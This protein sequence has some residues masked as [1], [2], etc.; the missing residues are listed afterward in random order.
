MLSTFVPDDDQQALGEA[1]KKLIQPFDDGYWL[2]CDREAAFPQAFRKAVADAGW[3]GIA[4][5]TS[6]GGA[7]LGVTEAAVMMEAIANSPGGMAA[8]SA[9][10]MNIFGPE[11]IVKHGSDRQRDAWLPDIIKG[12]LVTCFGVT[13]PDVG[14]DTTKI[15]TTA[16]HDG[17]HYRIDGQKIWTSTAKEADRVLLL[18]RTTP[19]EEVSK[20][21]LGLSLF[22]AKLDPAHVEVREIQKMGRHAVDSNQ[23]FFDGLPVSVDE[24]IGDEGAGF[25]Y[26]LNSLNPE[27]IL[28][29]AEA[30]GV[31]RQALDRAIAYAG[32]REVFGRLIGENQAIQHPLAKS[33]ME[34]ETA[35]LSTLNAA[36][37]YDGDK[38]SGVA[39]NMAKYLGAEAG[40]HACENAILTHGGMGY[41][42]EYHVER[43]FREVWI[44]RLAP[45]S[46]QLIL[47]HIA[48]RALGLPRSY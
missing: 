19:L 9:V 6:Y 33:W 10:H 14:L 30:I 11:A 45:V 35:W 4:M 7:G 20:P 17:N 38:P 3:L 24:R 28:I 2:T 23:V 1:I 39:A 44:N 31:G 21:T 8:A 48:E 32:E 27:R 22:F 34:L 46:Q 41:A 42:K 40:Y 25:S 26:L 43:L 12:D 37:L 5:P 13:E 29:A 36:A 18:A 16:K 47:C 15:K